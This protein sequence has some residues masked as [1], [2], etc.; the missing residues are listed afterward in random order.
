MIQ[1]YALLE[2]IVK[3]DQ[4]HAVNVILGHIKLRRANLPVW[5]V[6]RVT[7]VLKEVSIQLSVKLVFIARQSQ[8]IVVFVKQAILLAIN[9][10][11]ASVTSA[12]LDSSLQKERLHVQFVLEISIVKLLPVQCA[13]HV[14]RD[15]LATLALPMKALV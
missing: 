9:K 13:Q 4:H 15:E 8:R 12:C 1:I 3:P 6:Q 11:E 7:N 14:L 5:H 10:V 2:D